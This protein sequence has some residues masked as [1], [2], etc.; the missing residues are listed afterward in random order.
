MLL[1]RHAQA[2]RRRPVLLIVQFSLVDPLALAQEGA[3]RAVANG[4]VADAGARVEIGRVEMD[5][6]I[7]A[8]KVDGAVL[9]RPEAVDVARRV[10]IRGGDVGVTIATPVM[11][12]TAVPAG[13]TTSIGE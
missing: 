5:G 10:D 8:G 7:I 12:P 11:L 3:H 4:K 2:A 1:H 6:G 9:E 13:N